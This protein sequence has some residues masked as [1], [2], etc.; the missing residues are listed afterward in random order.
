MKYNGLDVYDVEFNDLVSVFN[1]VALVTEPA[2]MVDFIQLSKQEEGEDGMTVM[3]K[4]D[5]E[6]RIVSGPCLIPN[7][8]IYRNQGGRKFYIRY[9]EE[10]IAQMA[11]NFFRNGRQTEGNVEH[12][13]P[14]NGITFFE[15]YI[16]NKERGICPKEFE[17]LPDGTWILSAKVENDAVWELIKSGEVNG[18]SIDISN[19]SF[20]D[21]R[22][23]DSL[24]DLIE[25]LN[26]NND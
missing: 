26:N 22:V 11:V 14:V 16:L 7:Q 19:V 24:E 21:D 13:F 1:N 3:M 10:T 5:E 17:N 4:V 6:K 23:I 9:S 25:Y 20:K 18:F 12:Q 8:Y 2:I 15:S